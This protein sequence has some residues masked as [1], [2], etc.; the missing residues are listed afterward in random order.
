MRGFLRATAA[1]DDR[2]LINFSFEAGLTYQGL[3]ASRPDDTVGLGIAYGRISPQAAAYDR[4]VVAVTGMAMPIRDY[5]TAIELTY[6]MQVVPNWTIQ[7]DLQYIVHP[8][9]NVPNPNDPSGA[10]AIPN[11]LV[12]GLRTVLKF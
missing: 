3:V 9:G 10:T 7:P 5:E 4:D 12:L 11:A 2:N 8:G 6:R 1:P